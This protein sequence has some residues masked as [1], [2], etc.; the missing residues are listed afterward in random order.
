MT[1][2]WTALLLR[3]E[4]VPGCRVL[5]DAITAG[6]ADTFELELNVWT[7][8]VDRTTGSAHVEHSFDPDEGDLTLD[9]L[10]GGLRARLDGA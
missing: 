8:T 4:G 5:L 3:D 6:G 9:E 2:D 10:V 1:Q 7:V